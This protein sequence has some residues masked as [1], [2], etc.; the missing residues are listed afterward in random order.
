MKNIS[1]P[2]KNI[3]TRALAQMLMIILISVL[4][5]LAGNVMRSSPL[6]LMGDWSNKAQ[7]TTISGEELMVSL[8]DAKN[9]FQCPD[10]CFCGC[11]QQS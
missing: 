2:R 1:I 9:S 10:R 8:E 5:A 6:P 11:P 7:L 3:L 4:A